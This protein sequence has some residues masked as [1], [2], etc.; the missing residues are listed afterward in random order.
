MKAR[1]IILIAVITI[2][3]S[4]RK[5]LGTDNNTSTHELKVIELEKS[6]ITARQELKIPEAEKTKITAYINSK[7]SKTDVLGNSSIDTVLQGIRWEK[8]KIYDN[9][10]GNK[11]TVFELNI[12]GK[13]ILLL[14]YS[15][16]DKASYADAQ[17]AV[18][19][20]SSLASVDFLDIIGW[21]HNNEKTSFTG[22]LTYY[23]VTRQLLFEAGYEAGEKKFVKKFDKRANPSNSTNSGARCTSFYLVTHW[24]DGSADYEYLY[25]V[26][27]NDGPGGGCEQTR[28]LSYSSATAFNA[29]R[30]GGG[31]AGV[32]EDEAIVQ[33]FTN[34]VEF[35][36]MPAANIFGS[37]TAASG[38]TISDIITW[39]VAEASLGFWKIVASTRYS[40][41]HDRFYT[42]NMT[43]EDMYNMSMFET[44]GSQFVGSNTF[45]ESTWTQTG[46][47]N[48]ILNNN[49]SNTYGKSRVT[50]TIRHRLRLPLPISGG[51]LD[52]TFPVPGN[53]LR[54]YPR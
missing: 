16:K 4:C 37:A 1:L 12:A 49:T 46:L 9:N 13:N 7:R 23:K 53:E 54:F 5:N 18:I 15:Q 3:A 51:I 21:I 45:I 33:E 38:N 52:Y 19:K 22:T 47:L 17:I 34:Y 48:E 43:Y 50:G 8:F 30:C 26:C 41:I 10:L 6:K 27:D 31:G 25:S 24:S 2:F 39:H 29:S 42:V 35:Q 14:L 36:I 44:T 32:S 28:S 11:L 40:Y 20:Q